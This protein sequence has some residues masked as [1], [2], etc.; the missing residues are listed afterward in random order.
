MSN[1]YYF[2]SK[3]I[4]YLFLIRNVS[5]CSQIISLISDC[6]RSRWL[7]TISYISRE[8]VKV[9]NKRCPWA[10]KGTL[11]AMCWWGTVLVCSFWIYSIYGFFSRNQNVLLE[12]KTCS[13]QQLKE[14]GSCYYKMLTCTLLWV[15]LE[16][17]CFSH[18]RNYFGKM[19]VSFLIAICCIMV[20]CITNLNASDHRNQ[21]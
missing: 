13:I 8:G 5:R 16:P 6:P 2:P 12:I 1:G 18:S 4:L 7:S 15:C 9:L 14:G 11:K 20:F 17:W 3:L 19:L 10:G 21:A